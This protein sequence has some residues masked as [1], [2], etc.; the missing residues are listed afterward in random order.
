LELIEKNKNYRVKKIPIS[1]III[2]PSLDFE[3]NKHSIKDFLSKN[4]YSNVKIIPSEVPY[5]I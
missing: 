3:L 5:R 2:G 1:H 4:G